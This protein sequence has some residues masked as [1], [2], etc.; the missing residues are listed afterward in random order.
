MH[1]FLEFLNSINNK[2]DS[3]IIESIK[4]AY[5]AIIE[6][7]ETQVLIKNFPSVIQSNDWACGPAVVQS[8]LNFYGITIFQEDLFKELKTSNDTGTDIL[9]MANFFKH[10]GF[11]ISFGEKT[12]DELKAMIDDNTP[13]IIEIQAWADSPKAYEK[14]SNNS[15]FIVVIGYNDSGFICEDPYIPTKGFISYEELEKR[16]HSKSSVRGELLNKVAISITGEQPKFK[17]SK[18]VE[19]K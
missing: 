9:D 11:D 17:P 13:V 2:K 19:I 7:N 5:S 10:R 12:T 6:S 16:W 1:V 15:H 3:S 8:L 4:H 18:I 14:T